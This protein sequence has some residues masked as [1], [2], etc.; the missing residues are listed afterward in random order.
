MEIGP[1]SNKP[2]LPS[3]ADRS[4]DRQEA[5][6]KGA[7]PQDSVEI[8]RD[9]RCRLAELADAAL[10][11][12]KTGDGAVDRADRPREDKIEQARQRAREGF[13]DRPDIRDL[14]ADRLIEDLNL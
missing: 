12:E 10:R 1:L 3:P 6:E 7:P 11:A 2:P 5:V 14:I 13:Y 4:Q 8:S 9:A